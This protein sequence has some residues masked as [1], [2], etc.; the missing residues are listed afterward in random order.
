MPDNKYFN[1]L[2]FNYNGKRIFQMNRNSF[3]I[4]LILFIMIFSSCV[5]QS[6][7]ETVVIDFRDI[8]CLTVRNDTIISVEEDSNPLI[9]GA[10]KSIPSGYMMYLYDNDNIICIADTSFRI[11]K[12]CV[13][14]GMGP[15]ELAGVSGRFGQIIEVED[16]DSLVSVFDPYTSIVYGLNTDSGMLKEYMCFPNDMSKYIPS[17]VTRLKN[18]ELISPRGD[19]KYGMIAYDPQKKVVKEWSIGLKDI[20]IT[21][22]DESHVSLRAYD[23]N[24]K[25]GLI[26][27]IYGLIP[28]IIVHNESGDV[29]KTITIN[30]LPQTSDE[31]TDYFRDICLTDE[32]IF[33]LCGDPNVDEAN[34]VAVITHTG[35]P[36]A[37]YKIRPTQTIALDLT[38]SMLIA[39]NPN[40]DEGN[41]AVYGPME[42]IHK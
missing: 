35:D 41:I 40:I 1:T 29:I 6:E 17:N 5:N 4:M 42:Y 18:G 38:K 30:S 39:T 14:K 21:H 11:T 12:L 9:V 16:G 2:I 8:P 31:P 24:E 33:V 36:V 25:S 32:Y 3:A 26:A 13:E 37:A 22:P 19:F 7:I 23:Y 20:D 34:Y 15:T 27:E 28:T 10:T